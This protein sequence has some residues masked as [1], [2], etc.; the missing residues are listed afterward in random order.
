M[1]GA[2]IGAAGALL[3]GRQ[4]NNAAA[5]ATREANRAN[6]HLAKNSVRYRVEDARAAGINPL[7][8]LGAP[9][10]GGIVSAAPTF[11]N[12]LGEAAAQVGTAV[13]NRPTPQERQRLGLENALLEAQIAQTNAGTTALLGEARSRTMVSA[14]IAAAQG[15]AVPTS[16][17]PVARG[18]VRAPLAP[19]DFVGPRTL[20]QAT[21][22]T[23]VGRLMRPEYLGYA[24][25][26]DV[27]DAYGEGADFIYGAELANQVADAL[28]RDMAGSPIGR[29]A[30]GIGAAIGSL[31]SERRPRVDGPGRPR[32]PSYT[33]T[34]GPGITPGRGRGGH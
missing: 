27:T 22:A 13:A 30:D 33:F 24:P 20:D 32:N 28:R 26:M 3:G 17:V 23:P 4:N 7:A 1:W 11:D 15:G 16:N 18:A 8:A 25:A 14:S 29:A 6:L 10:M 19:G 9:T 12:G 21:L 31:V 34:P 2:L 5:K